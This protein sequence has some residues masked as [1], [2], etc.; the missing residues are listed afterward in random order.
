MAR[1]G[2][3]WGGKD[4]ERLLEGYAILQAIAEGTTDALYA[5]DA[6]GRYLM[7]NEAG[8]RE[9]GRPVEEIIGRSDA[10]LFPPEAAAEI[11]AHDR[12]VMA[13]GEPRSYEEQVQANGSERIYL[14]TKGPYRDGEGKIVGVVGISRDIT[15]RKL[16]EA[17]RERARMRATFFAEAGALL[18]S[19]L[20]YQTTLRNVARL[21]IPDIADWCA[22]DITDAEG[23]LVQVALAHSDPEKLALAEEL[24]RDYPPDPDSEHGAPRVV[25]TGEPLLYPKISDALLERGTRDE[26][27]LELMHRLGFVSAMV[28]PLAGRGETLGAI[29]FVSSTPGRRFDDEDLR[30][31]E[32]VGRRAGIAVQN[33]RL[34][35]ERSYIAQTL[36]RS[37]L[38]PV[39]PS[40]PGLE[41][42]ARFHAA[43]EGFEV[44]GDFYDLFAT[45]HERW[46]AVIGD[47]C[48][49]GPDAAVVTALARYTL[50]AAA[51]QVSEPSRILTLLNE[52]MLHDHAQQ[53]RFCTVAYASL[54]P[55]G[56]VVELQVAS[57]GHPLPFVL[58]GD[59]RVER[60]GSSGTLIGIV[61]EVEL[62]DTEARLQ[63]GD[64]LVLYTDGVI[65]ARRNGDPLGEDG[66]AELLAEC[67]GLGPAAI[68]ERVETAAV[69][70]WGGTVGDDVAVVVLRATSEGA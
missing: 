21:A 40:I 13:A 55:A 49:K 46:A 8:A 9:I 61:P 34:Y 27:H 19:S 65:D 37:L 57:G 10:E 52:T 2:M 48:G 11:A 62:R 58:R 59:G 38:P 63:P 4:P 22:V 23:M 33:A 66:L 41:V 16:I 51:M 7:I 18:E 25:R 1:Q 26:R 31:A 45:R 42:A 17:E 56:S 36:Q 68:A 70:H 53:G 64:T 54:Q 20:D 15:E 32:E 69:K 28:V 14:S 47:V 12:S 67:G 39:L 29:T 6:H 3:N 44:G 43:G 35:S 5:K 60:L 50:R 30:L 24:R